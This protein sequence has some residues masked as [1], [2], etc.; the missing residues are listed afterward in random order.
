MLKIRPAR[1]V[2]T[3]IFLVA[4]VELAHADTWDAA[5]DFSLTNPN[6]QW[7]YGY[8]TTGG[9]FTPFTLIDPF[10]NPLLEMWSH[11]N[12]N[13]DD[14]HPFIA[15]NRTGSVQTGAGLSLLPGRLGFHPGPGPADIYAMI[16]WTAPYAATFALTAA[17]TNQDRGVG[18]TV[19]VHILLNGAAIYSFDFMGASFFALDSGPPAFMANLTLV[20]GDTLDFIVGNARNFVADSTGLSA[21]ITSPLTTTAPIPEPGTLALVAAAVTCCAWMRRR[22]R[23]GR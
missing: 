22:G 10:L 3:V 7:S 12:I 11:G 6:G 15:F 9:S 21:V 14:Q 16:R 8:S 18:N 20:A 1:S 5:A 19:D 17:F 2:L 4:F 13:F 23:R